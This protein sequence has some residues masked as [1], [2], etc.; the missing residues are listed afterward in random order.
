MRRTQTGLRVSVVNLSV[1]SGIGIELLKTNSNLPRNQSKALIRRF[2]AKDEPDLREICFATGFQGLPA[3][4]WLDVN[5]A[6]FTDLWLHYYIHKTPDMVLVAE[7]EGRV[8]GYLTGCVDIRTRDRYYR[9]KFPFFMLAGFCSGR[10]RLGK[11]TLKALTRH[12][13]DGLLRG[14]PHVSLQMPYAE[15]HCNMRRE[16]QGRH[17]GFGMLLTKAFCGEVK[18]FGISRIRVSAVVKTS[19]LESRYRYVASRYDF[20][21]T[22]IYAEVDKGEYA[23]VEAC[24]DFQDERLHPRWRRFL[25]EASPL[26]SADD[27]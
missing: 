25:V 27:G 23:L 17:G 20:R 12:L 11:R 18:R 6:L 16:Y 1:H 21:P 8:V 19:E 15:F 22:T 14:R 2:Q 24:V 5:E 3:S 7:S 9:A 13:R 10:Y 4:L 26:T